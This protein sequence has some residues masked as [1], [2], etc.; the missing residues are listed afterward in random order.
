MPELRKRETAYKVRI[1]DLLRGNQMFESYNESENLNPRLMQVE[2]GDKKIVRVNIVA[3]VVDK[4]ESQGETKFASITI[5]DG[6]GQIKAR[7][8]REDI[9]KIS[10]IV[11]GDTV[12]V[13]GLVRS[14]NKELYILPEIIKKYEPK[15]LLVRKLEIDKENKFSYEQNKGTKAFRDQIIDLIKSSEK[16]EGIDKEQIIMALKESNPK[17]ISEEIK[18]LLEDGIIYEPRP[19]RVRYLG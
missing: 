2:L 4:F 1:G 5:D 6:S 11:Q 3:N 10:N 12:L 7:V 15:Y 14:F 18:R 19:G 8:F 9:S 13:I 17:I 16:N